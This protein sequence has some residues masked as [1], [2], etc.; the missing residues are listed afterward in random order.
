MDPVASL[1]AWLDRVTFADLTIDQVT[2]RLVDEVV[3]WGRAQQWR[4]YRRPPSVLPLPPP[5]D[6]RHSVLDVGCARP[7]GSALAIEIDHTDRGRTVTKLLAEAE[8][9]RLPIWVRWGPGRFREPPPPV[10]MVA[11]PV[12]R[13][14][15]LYSRMPERPAP[16]H[17]AAIATIQEQTIPL[18]SDPPQS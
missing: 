16:S 6:G 3:A 11:C 17:S 4:V 8:A 12:S 14:G 7:D 18:G 9:G 15:G 5:L 1:T 2:A 13:H 10:R